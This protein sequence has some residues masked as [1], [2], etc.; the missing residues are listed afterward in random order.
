MYRA[1]K[2]FGR[3]VSALAWAPARGRSLSPRFA[4]MDAALRGGEGELQRVELRRGDLDTLGV[5]EE[6]QHR[7]G[8]VGTP[9]DPLLL[10]HLVEPPPQRL[11]VAVGAFA[12]VGLGDDAQRRDP[13]RGRER[14]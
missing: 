8:A 3:R 2:S 9:V 11:G 6:L 1:R 4:L 5:G 14:V 7:E 13:G 12:G 10:E